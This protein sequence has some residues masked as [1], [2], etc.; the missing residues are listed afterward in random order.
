[1]DNL[2]LGL[3]KLIFSKRDAS[4]TGSKPRPGRERTHVQKFG[5]NRPRRDCSPFEEVKA[6]FIEM[7]EKREEDC[8]E[9]ELRDQEDGDNEHT[10]YRPRDMSGFEEID[11]PEID[12]H[13]E[14]P[15]KD[16]SEKAGLG[17][18]E[19]SGEYK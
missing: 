1:M 8:D 15:T 13:C 17:F 9:E 14:K 18:E 10:E 4:A 16:G 3:K 2:S 7:A 5:K 11:W 12:G 6:D 19:S